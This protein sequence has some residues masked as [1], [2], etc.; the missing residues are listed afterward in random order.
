[1]ANFDSVRSAIIGPLEYICRPKLVKPCFLFTFDQTVNCLAGNGTISFSGGSEI[2]YSNLTRAWYG[3][4]LFGG[5]DSRYSILSASTTDNVG[6]EWSLEFFCDWYTGDVNAYCVLDFAGFQ[7]KRTRNSLASF[8]FAGNNIS[9]ASHTYSALSHNAFVYTGGNL[10]IFENGSLID[11]KT[12]DLTSN[13]QSAII[14][15]AQIGNTGVIVS[16]LRLV[17]KALG[18]ASTYPV[19]SGPY[20]GYEAL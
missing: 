16:N 17:P 7:Y 10:R 11:T 5:G 18:T 9:L 13:P 6:E 20:T 2:R 14:S 12:L 4:F 15:S 3:M 8:T 1:M 19:P